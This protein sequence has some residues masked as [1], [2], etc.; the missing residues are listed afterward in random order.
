M[1]CLRTE[2]LA[3]GSFEEGVDITW[4][5]VVDCIREWPNRSTNFWL[6]DFPHGSCEVT[7]WIIGQILLDYGFGDWTLVYGMIDTDQRPDMSWGG[8]EWLEFTDEEGRY[9]AIDATWNQFPWGAEPILMTVTPPA[10]ELY[11]TN[12]RRHLASAKLQWFEHDVYTSPLAYVR[13][14]L[15]GC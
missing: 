8:H 4:N 6:N 1:A 10:A 15:R 3:Q 14:A 7:S 12:M 9:F 11:T 2:L 13:Q 5:R